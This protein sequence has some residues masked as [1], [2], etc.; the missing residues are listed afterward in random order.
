MH[1][2]SKLGSVNEEIKVISSR[3]DSISSIMDSLFTC[4]KPSNEITDKVYGLVQS[5]DEAVQRAHSE[6]MANKIKLEVV[7]SRVTK[8]REEIT[9]VKK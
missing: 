7:S 4:V 8:N 2:D 5:M 3:T 1:T 6:I 9:S